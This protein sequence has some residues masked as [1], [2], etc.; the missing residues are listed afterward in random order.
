MGRM[1]IPQ[2]SVK[3]LHEKITSQDAFVLIDVR[4][5]EE[6]EFCKIDQ[7]YLIPLARLPKELLTL[8]KEKSYVLMCKSG[9][10]STEAVKLFIEN[11]FDD[12]KNL[13]GGITQWALEIDPSMPTY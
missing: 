13:T 8:R 11:G 7:S 2:I 12:V 3:E 5:M 6:Y 10:R 4:E 1:K 9:G